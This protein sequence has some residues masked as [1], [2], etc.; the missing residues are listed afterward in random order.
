MSLTN[1]TAKF[2]ALL[3][4]DAI[5]TSPLLPNKALNN[6]LPKLLPLRQ[7]FDPL[8]IAFEMS[9]SVCV[10]LVEMS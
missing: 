8:V 1:E 5:T 4:S 9:L 7:L 3:V 6:N 2:K 10:S